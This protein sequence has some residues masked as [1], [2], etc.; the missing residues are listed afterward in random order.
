[1]FPAN[2]RL[3][4]LY[5]EQQITLA[6]SIEIPLR[7]QGQGLTD[8][9]SSQTQ[10]IMD[11][12]EMPDF[13]AGA[14]RD[15]EVLH[16]QNGSPY[17]KIVPMRLGKLELALNGRF[18]DGGIVFQ[19]LMLDVRPSQKQPEQLI[20][21]PGSA[22]R[23]NMSTL[24]LGVAGPNTRGALQVFAKYEGLDTVVK[25]DPAFATFSVTTGEQPAPFEFDKKTGFL[26]P[27][28]TG[29][30]LVETTFGGRTN[31]TCVVVTGGSG[32]PP[33]EHC[34]RLL[35]PGEKLGSVE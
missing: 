2:D 4:I 11:N 18:P 3:E 21:G 9:E 15:V 31:L 19:K 26:T 6:E 12:R 35:S 13:V 25:I 10:Y 27:I 23:R 34:Q 14:K 33:N 22:P 5:P 24:F 16:H 1:V 17:V 8:L 7:I 30:A 29:Q 28:Q 32:T 20:I